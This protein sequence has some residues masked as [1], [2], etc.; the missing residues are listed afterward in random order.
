M[1]CD[2]S[3]FLPF[4]LF[5]PMAGSNTFVIMKR[6]SK[7]WRKDLNVA[8]DFSSPDAPRQIIPQRWGHNSKGFLP[9]T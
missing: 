1:Q 7:G 6:G 3:F 9:V 5:F 4:L 2:L 8:M